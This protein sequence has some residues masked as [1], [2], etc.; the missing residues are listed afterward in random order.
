MACLAYLAGCALGLVLT[1]VEHLKAVAYV[2]VFLCFEGFYSIDSSVS[3][4]NFCIE[5]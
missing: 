5:K 1:V 3:V 4:N 2:R